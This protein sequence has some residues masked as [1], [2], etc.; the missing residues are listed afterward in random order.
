MSRWFGLAATA[1]ALGMLAMPGTALGQFFPTQEEAGPGVTISGD[2]VARVVAPRR[3]SETSIERAIAA[4]EPVAIGRAVRDARR[5]AAAIAGAVGVQLGQ[6]STVELQDVSQQF[7]QLRRHCRRATR[8]RTRR[9]RVP[10]FSVASATV[11]FSIVGGAA[12]GE[13]ARTVSAYGSASAPVHPTDRRSNS[14]IRRAIFAARLA[15]TPRAAVAAAR[16]AGTAARS[17]GLAL[18][19]IVSIAEQQQPYF[20]DFA[21]GTFGP[22]RFCGFVRRVFLRRDPDTGQRR[23]VRGRRR[24][25]CRVP[26]GYSLRLEAKYEAG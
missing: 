15:V 9:C 12:G 2:G 8:G 13:G 22:G 16:N 4:A 1:A 11:A 25:S 17:A 24:R 18:G 23:V 14:S 20:Y 7:G 10:A 3:L 26:P 19:R 21:L 5:R 6:A